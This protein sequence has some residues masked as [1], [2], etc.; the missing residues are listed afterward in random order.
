MS[1]QSMPL[2]KVQVIKNSAPMSE[3]SRTFMQTLQTE[4]NGTEKHEK[5]IKAQY[6]LNS[7]ERTFLLANAVITLS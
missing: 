1:E 3:F 2:P 5:A 4:S 7:L 6:H